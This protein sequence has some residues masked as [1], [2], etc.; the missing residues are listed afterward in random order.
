MIK[1]VYVIRRRADLTPAAFRTRWLSHGPL[2]SEV[3]EAIRARR[4][5][6]SHTIDTPLNAMLADSRGMAEGYDGITEVWWD[7]MEELVAG[8]SSAESLDAQ[9]RLLADER[10]FIDLENSFVFLTEEHPIFDRA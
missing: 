8:M 3:A 7:N 10:E 6:Q 9:R 1:L 5:I 2:V 4:Y